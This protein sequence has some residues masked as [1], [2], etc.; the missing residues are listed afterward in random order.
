MRNEIEQ[1]NTVLQ[2][3][4]LGEA[5]PSF[6]SQDFG[7]LIKHINAVSA[8]PFG[9]EVL[10]R[11]VLQTLLARLSA[12]MSAERELAIIRGSAGDLC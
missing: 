9:C 7:S 1:I 6:K 12:S 4:L 2:D 11:K 8:S 5:P 3:A 10:G